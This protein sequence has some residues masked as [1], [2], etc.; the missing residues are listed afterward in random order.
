MTIDNITNLFSGIR[1]QD[2]VDILLMSYVIFRLYV[3]FKGTNIFS[4]GIGF[5]LL[6]FFQKVASS[7]GLIVTSWAIQGVT[8]VAAIILI[9]IFRNEIRSA[10]QTKSLRSLLYG[11][12]IKTIETPG[13]I[14]VESVYQLASNRHGALI[15][16]PGR[17][18]VREMV[19]S[20]ISW[21]GIISKE[22][23]TSIFWPDNPVHDGAAVISGGKVTQVGAILPLSRRKDFPSYY[24]TRH[25]AAAGLAEVTDALVIVASEERGS[26]TVAKNSSIE[27]V[28]DKKQLSAIIKEH[29]GVSYGPSRIFKKQQT[30]LALAAIVSIILVTGIWLSFTRGIDTLISLEVPIEYINR[31]SE[32]DIYD[33]SVNA[34]RLDLSGSGTLLKSIKSENIKVKV[35]LINCAVGVNNCLMSDENVS[36]PPG[37]YLKNIKPYYVKVTLDKTIDKKIPLQ[38]DWKGKLPENLT[39][40]SVILEPSDVKINGRSTILKDLSTIYTEKISLDGINKSGELTANIVLGNTSLKLVGNPGT[41]KIRYVVKEKVRDKDTGRQRK[42]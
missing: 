40:S 28:N 26:I 25:R 22:M 31:P 38:V 10:L 3:L 4:V 37:I 39:L 19:H 20:G 33:T 11:F 1:W 9:V 5:A 27:T 14:I 29:L 36:L 8:A 18:D 21:D 35:D 2:I 6:W 32:L 16:L 34:V 30:E 7:L 24:G 15:V 23:I 12:H 13:D 41:V 17:E 42:K